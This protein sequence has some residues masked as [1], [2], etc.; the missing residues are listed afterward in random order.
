MH[1]SQRKILIINNSSKLSGAEVSLLAFVD[2]LQQ[3]EL[4]IVA[5]PSAEG[6][7]YEELVSRNLTVEKFDLRRFSKAQT[8]FSKMGYLFQVLRTSA[9]LARL[10]RKEK[11]DLIY[12]NSNQSL[13]YAL[14]A[15]L[16]TGKKTVWHVRDKIDNRFLARLLSSLVSRIICIS[17]FIAG[18]FPEMKGKKHLVYNGI[19]THRWSPS[20]KTGFLQKELGLPQGTLLVGQI[21]QLLP[22]KNYS[23]L[24]KLAM[25]VAPSFQNVHFLIIGEDLFGENR[26]YVNGLKAL[27]EEH[28]L[29]PRISF[30]GHRKN[31]RDCMNELDIIVHFALH[32]PFG[33]VVMEAMA[34]EK[35]VVAYDSGGVK[36]IV[37]DS[38]T[39]FLAPPK[40]YSEAANK[41]LMLLE[42]ESLRRSLGIQGR[43]DVCERFSAAAMAG[44]VKDI[45]GW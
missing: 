33:R 8:L 37:R 38:K 39:G 4:F 27:I 13:P 7:L 40:N 15:R 28:G 16:F 3:P 18:Q 43:K 19:D 21:G 14:G 5:I 20:A 24:V 1:P 44:K 6:D 32:E 35:P 31:I 26:E 11:I 36:E 22:W 23:D 34:L 25:L 30:L 17:G 45:L 2:A 29:T 42:D 9:R 12:A 10:V 41:V